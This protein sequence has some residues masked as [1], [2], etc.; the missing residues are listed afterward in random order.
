MGLGPEPFG[1]AFQ[2][3][4]GKY[5]LEQWAARF[6]ARYGISV[7]EALHSGFGQVKIRDPMEFPTPLPTGP[8]FVV[9]DATLF[10]ATGDD[11]GTNRRRE[12]TTGTGSGSGSGTG[13]GSGDGS[14]SGS[15]SGSGDGSGDGSGS[16]SSSNPWDGYEGDP[17]LPPG[18]GPGSGGEYCTL[19]MEGIDND[20]HT[21]SVIK[22]CPLTHG[23]ATVCSCHTFGFCYWESGGSPPDCADP[24]AVPPDCCADASC[25]YCDG[26]CPSGIDMVCCYSDGTIVAI[27]FPTSGIPCLCPAAP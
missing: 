12:G 19:S 18:C 21:C 9:P 8:Q 27:L 1:G 17:G 2:N 4:Q 10:A 16:G 5:L 3:S 7:K 13:S 26:Q 15:G 20:C 6:I 24:D 11:E 14:G 23:G 22:K 25:P